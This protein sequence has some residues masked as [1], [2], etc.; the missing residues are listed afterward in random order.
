MR[1]CVLGNQSRAVFLFWRV[2]MNEARARGHSVLCLVPQGDEKSDKNIEDLGVSI[3][4]YSLDRKGINPLRDVR[5]FLDLKRIF[6]E[7]Q[8][9]LLFATTIKPVIYGCIAARLA[10]IPHVY[11]TITGL[12]YAFEADSFLKKIVHAVSVVLYRTA[13]SRIE[14]VFFQNR[15]DA[16]LFR[17]CGILTDA[18]RVLFARGTG[19][20]TARFPVQPLPDTSQGLV[21]LTVGRL[22]IA[23]GFCEFAEAA[24]RV[25][26]KYPQCRFQILGPRE[27]G[28]GSISDE[29]L[30]QWK[31]EGA[32]EYLGATSDVVPYVRNCHVV[33]LASWREGIP[34]A[35]MEAMSMGRACLVT[36]VPGCREAVTDGDNGFLVPDK[37]PAALAEAMERFI[38]QPELLQTM[39]KRGRELA[40]QIFDAHVVATGI[41]QDMHVP[42]S[43]FEGNNH[44]DK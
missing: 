41:L 11:A 22:L 21:F 18:S 23:K 35:I 13:L 7:E 3:R 8:I 16:R 27:Q 34:T 31:E 2:L 6:H 30:Q 10:D 26:K 14:G 12:G 32:V 5:T 28:L 44:H 37:D 20:D 39:G 33:V 9:D 19:V 40:E 17:S 4:H 29:R 42:A 43:P 15:D 1:I 24:R 36:N 25:K 38:C